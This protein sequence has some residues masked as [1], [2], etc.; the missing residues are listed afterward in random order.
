[1]ATEKKVMVSPPSMAQTSSC[2]SSVSGRDSFLIK[3]RAR[4]SARESPLSSLELPPPFHVA[5]PPLSSAQ[6]QDLPLTAPPSG[7]KGELQPVL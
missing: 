6:L 7:G 5:A 2:V 3:E 4:A 1:M